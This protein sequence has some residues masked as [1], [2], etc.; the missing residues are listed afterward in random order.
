MADI[1]PGDHIVIRGGLQNNAFVPKSVM[2]LSTEQWERVQQ[3]AQG[4][5]SQ[6]GAQHAGAPANNPP[7]Q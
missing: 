6:S 1:Q 2:L 3:F 7:Q 5:A 4:G